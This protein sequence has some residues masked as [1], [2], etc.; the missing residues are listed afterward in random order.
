MTS[1]PSALRQLSPSSNI[2]A[3]IDSKSFNIKLTVYDMG[4]DTKKS[5]K[6]LS[7]LKAEL[8]DCDFLPAEIT[9]ETAAF[10]SASTTK[11]KRVIKEKTFKT[12]LESGETLET[13]IQ[14][15]PSVAVGLPITG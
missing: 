15:I 13:K 5:E 4:D 14:I 10:F 1:Q 8:E 11:L 6:D 7:F 2:N 12:K 3:L 9:L